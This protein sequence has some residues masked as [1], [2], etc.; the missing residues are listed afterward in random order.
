MN[1]NFTLS[2]YKI[3]W[4]EFRAVK[5]IVTKKDAKILRKYTMLGNN[6]RNGDRIH[7]H[8]ASKDMAL[9]YIDCKCEDFK[10]LSKHYEVRICT[11][12]Q[13]S[14]GHIEMMME[15]CYD[16]HNKG[17]DKFAHGNSLY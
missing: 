10:K 14:L 4:V 5:G 13:F 15:L 8:F 2:P 7:E 1:K 3:T 6:F 12:K 11:Y 9:A 16:Q 17:Y